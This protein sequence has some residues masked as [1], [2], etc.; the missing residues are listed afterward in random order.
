MLEMIFNK[1][2]LIVLGIVVGIYLLYRAMFSKNE[3]EEDYDRLYNKI[4]TSEEYK[5]KGQ[6]DK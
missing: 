5:V 1:T 3:F 4:L 2:I 6:Y